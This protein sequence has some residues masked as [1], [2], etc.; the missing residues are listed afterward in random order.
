MIIG[1]PREVKADEYRVSLT[2]DKVDPLVKNGHTVLVERGAGVGA[3]FDDGDYQAAGATL[4]SGPEEVFDRADLVVKVKEPQ[5]QEYEL[6][7]EGQ[8]LF[9]FLHL[10]SAPELT[11]ALLTARVTGISPFSTL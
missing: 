11:Q 1:I 6:F 7:R 10:A 2:P 4:V 5:P 3:S 9:T 8:V